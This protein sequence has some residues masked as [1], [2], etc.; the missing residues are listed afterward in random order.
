VYDNFDYVK[1]RKNMSARKSKQLKTHVQTTPTDITVASSIATAAIAASSQQRQLDYEDAINSVVGNTAISNRVTDCDAS[2]SHGNS[3]ECK[4]AVKL[5]HGEISLATLPFDS[6][7]DSLPSIADM[8]EIIYTTSSPAQT[9]QTILSNFS[10]NKKANESIKK[11]QPCKIKKYDDE[12]EEWDSACIA[13][14]TSSRK[15]VRPKKANIRYIASDAESEKENGNETDL[16]PVK[17]AKV[18]EDDEDWLQ[19]P[20]VEVKAENKKCLMEVMQQSQKK[21]AATAVKG[22]PGKRRKLGLLSEQDGIEQ[23][24]LL[25]WKSGYLGVIAVCFKHDFSTVNSV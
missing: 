24:N 13:S 10:E 1:E 17:A 14:A 5:E 21:L 6:D 23:L 20:A 4:S 12:D 9:K 8:E 19:P 2:T 25:E 11:L 16:K 7:S 3:E 15:S 22:P 18:E